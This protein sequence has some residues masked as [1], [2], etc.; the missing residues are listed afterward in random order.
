MVPL[1][2]RY[3]HTQLSGRCTVVQSSLEIYNKWHQKKGLHNG[4][5]TFTVQIK[6]TENETQIN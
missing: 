5:S 4:T 1:E 3:T 2:C 6:S